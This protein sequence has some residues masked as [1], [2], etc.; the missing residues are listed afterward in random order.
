MIKIIT[1]HSLAAQAA[2]KWKRQYPEDKMILSGRTK[3]IHEQ[4]VALGPIPN[5][6]DVDRIIGNNSWTRVP[7]CSNCNQ[8]EGLDKV[9]EVGQVPN[10]ESRHVYLCATCVQAIWDVMFANTNASED[11]PMPTFV[12]GPGVSITEFWNNYLYRYSAPNIEE[13]EK[14]RNMMQSKKKEEKK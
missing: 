8:D 14:V 6:D 13:L 4:L 3:N 7:D 9:I 10:Y 2:V 12:D 5:P 11:N 1:R